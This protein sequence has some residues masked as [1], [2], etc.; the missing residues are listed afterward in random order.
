MTMTA[1]ELNVLHSHIDSASNFLEFGAGASTLYAA[2]VPS[3]RQIDS[4]ESSAEFVD[5]NLK[6]NPVI[7]EALSAGRLLFHIIDIGKTFYWGYPA[8]FCK[9][10]VWP[11]YS[12]RIFRQKSEH[13]L[14]LIDGRFRVA[15]TLNTIL[16]T[17]EH[18]KILIHDFWNRPHYHVVLSFLETQAEVDTLG[19]FTKR[20][21]IDQ[22][23]VKSLI[24]KYKYLPR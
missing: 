10:H 2:S 24:D 12:F 17:P 14:V 1:A 7:S 9:K 6:P 4:V 8:S 19:V 11:D 3:I 23:Q 18:C 20:P 22:R 13:D 15:C 21:G 16:N 5:E